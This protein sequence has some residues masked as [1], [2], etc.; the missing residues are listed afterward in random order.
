MK[1]EKFTEIDYDAYLGYI[2]IIH[3]FT[4]IIK[5]LATKYAVSN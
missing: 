1:S 3:H 5:Y 2:F 4:F